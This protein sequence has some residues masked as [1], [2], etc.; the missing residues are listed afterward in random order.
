MHTIWFPAPVCV[1]FRRLVN[2]VSSL[3]ISHHYLAQK[4]EV[5]DPD[6]N[7]AVL[8]SFAWLPWTSRTK[9]VLAV[10]GSTLQADQDLKPK[11][12][13]RPR[14]KSRPLDVIHRLMY[15]P[16]LYDPV[17]TPRYPIALCH[18]G[19][20]A[21]GDVDSYLTSLQVS[22]ASTS[23]GLHHSPS[24]VNTTGPT[25]SASCG[26]RSAQRSS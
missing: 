15:S 19:F 20:C 21:T 13:P 1:L 22:T 2:V 18:G 6:T 23:V 4:G 12:A 10:D 11:P 9:F 8:K 5:S 14:S 26:R 3:S 7:W 24:Y 25:C 17:R 16:A